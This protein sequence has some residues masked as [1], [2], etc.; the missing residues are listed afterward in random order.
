MEISRLK[1]HD[2]CV[3]IQDCHGRIGIFRALH[4]GDM[5]CAVP[6]LRA[7]RAGCHK[8][9]ITLIGLPSAAE[10]AA[11]Y[12]HYLDDFLPFPGH[13]QLP[14]LRVSEGRYRAFVAHLPNDFEWL[15][16]LHGD[17][18]LTN[19]ILA[20]WPTRHRA[21]FV[22]KGECHNPGFVPYP[23]GHEIDRLLVLAC[24]LGGRGSADLEFPLRSEDFARLK[25]TAA[26]ADLFDNEYV[27]VHPG[28]RAPSRRLAPEFFEDVIAF[29]AERVRVVLTGSAAEWDLNAG[30]AHAGPGVINAAGLTSL[31]ALGALIA[32]ARCVVTND[33]G[34]SH[35]CA[36]LH[37]PSLVIVSG[38]DPDRWAPKNR[39]LHRLLDVRA[40]LVPERLTDAV[41]E[42][43]EQTGRV[44]PC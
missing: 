26:F 15:I 32:G 4:L 16:Q 33:S 2:D 44:L 17:G 35:L 39:R 29:L 18:S 5:L 13:P 30:L 23:A 22:A 9:H 7:L 1:A 42:L 14:E 36:A 34:P 27:V 24:H 12:P 21:G 19:G 31:G 38:S 20:E 37:T 41:A 25:G 28:S 10:W 43:W 6:A 11:R 3:P 40:G 8:A